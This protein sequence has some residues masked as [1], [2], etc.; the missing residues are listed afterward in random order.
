MIINFRIKS[1]FLNILLI[2]GLSL[3]FFSCSMLGIPSG[4]NWS[5][6]SG[7]QLD[8]VEIGMI[9]V[10]KNADWDSV[11]AE[12]RRLLPL[13]LAKAGYK[14]ITPGTVLAEQLPAYWVDAVLI[15]REY[16]ENWKTRRSLSAEILIRKNGTV[17]N[18]HD[19]FA[20][21]PGEKTVIAAGKMLLSGAKS[22]SSSKTLHDLLESAL[23][24][25]LR[26]LPKK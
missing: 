25:A 23:S 8:T 11:E 7:K 9:R 3:G 4:K 13:L 10:D 20:D 18:A 22:F 24:N 12:T 2:L 5:P 6:D 1:V 16:M 21:D 15:E 19:V 17:E 14:Q 26:A